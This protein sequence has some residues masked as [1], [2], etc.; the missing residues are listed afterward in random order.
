MVVGKWSVLDTV[1]RRNLAVPLP[2]WAVSSRPLHSWRGPLLPLLCTGV[3]LLLF[4]LSLSGADLHRMTDLGLITAYHADSL[5]LLGCSLFL[6]TV[7]YA[8]TLRLWPLRAPLPFL[9]LL[10]LVFVLY[11][12]PVLL[13]PTLRREPAWRHVGLVDYIARHGTVDPGLDAYH[14]WPG[15][16]LLVASIIS[17]AGLPDAVE[18]GVF[19][20]LFFS[21]VCIGPLKLIFDSLTQDQ[22]LSWFALWIF[23]VTNW[24][25]Q[26]YFSPQ[27]LVYFIHL[28]VLAILLNWLKTGV[29]IPEFLSSLP[30][31]VR[32]F[33]TS[34]YISQPSAGRLQRAALLII[35][36]LL[37][38]VAAAS[39]QLTPF[40]T[41]LTVTALVLA[42]RCTARGLPA[43]MGVLLTSWLMFGAIGYISGHQPWS[44]VGGVSSIV[45]SSVT[46][47]LE[48]SEEHLLIVQLRLFFTAAL[49]ALAAAGGVRR[50]WH[51]S[52]DLSLMIV[53]A[54]PFALLGGQSYGGE[55]LIRTY[56]YSL[57]AAAFF[58]AALVFTSPRPTSS[59]RSFGAVILISTFLIAGFFFTRYGNERLD[60]LS[61]QEVDA[62]NYLYDTA[63][64]TALTLVGSHNWPRLFRGYEQ[65]RFRSLVV[66][67]CCSE[68]LTAFEPS[69]NELDNAVEGVLRI[70]RER[71][72][73]RILFTRGQVAAAEMLGL[74]AP[75]ALER[76]QSA[77]ERSGKVT[78]VYENADATI[79]A[80]RK[81]EVSAGG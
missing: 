58:C 54:V 40:A 20:S 24:V 21:I 76:F 45:S 12:L 43:L 17:V 55:V 10:V 60:Y 36:A 11:G 33:I 41:L 27:A 18:L 80:L 50:L 3:G 72:G 44:E 66:S 13:E 51:G 23:Y 67:D 26:D 52:T 16:F 46:R 28:F 35:A 22:R 34:E 59:W 65:Y 38:L 29:R 64:P 78:I 70:L 69:Q 19:S 48:G 61:S 68:V 37:F 42:G 9:Q 8:L 53:G 75:G 74:A 73:T 56:L 7:G 14:N 77:L 6:L 15:F 47:R 49:W 31:P 63:S 71:P 1:Q 81:D 32:T 79:Y 5:V 57:P 25:S 30:V 62:A 39:H 4:A 2:A